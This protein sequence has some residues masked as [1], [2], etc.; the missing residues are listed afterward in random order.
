MK[1]IF[2]TASIVLSTFVYSQTGNV[3]INTA[4][5][6]ATLDVAGS[7]T[8]ATKLDGVIAPRITGEQLRLKT[9]TTDQ[10]GAIVYVTAAA[11]APL[12]NQVIKVS[13]SGYYYF[14]GTIWQT[15]AGSSGGSSVEPWNEATTTNP[16]TSN[17]QNIYQTGN[18]GIGN[19]DPTNALHVTAVANPARLEGLQ[20]GNSTESMV[21][22]DASG[23]LH[24]LPYPM[25]V[26]RL[27]VNG[28]TAGTSYTFN[29]L[30]AMRFD[31]YDSYG[32]LGVL[33]ASNND[34][35]FV[36]TIV[37]SVINEGVT[38]PSFATFSGE[39]TVPATRT[40][41]TV[42]L[43][44]GIYEVT[45]NVRGLVDDASN[46]NLNTKLRILTSINNSYFRKTYSATGGN[47]EAENTSSFIMYLN[48]DGSTTFDIDFLIEPI[49]GNGVLSPNTFTVQDIAS[50]GLNS[51]G[52]D[53]KVMRSEIIIKK[54]GTLSMGSSCS[55]KKVSK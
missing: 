5:P 19:N 54:I 48:G 34:Y 15:M 41:D 44:T 12:D 36:N 3:G 14:D 18:V 13:A 30:S 7:P 33:P 40:T 21:V 46:P 51:C 24:T 8:I 26:L 45:F 11:L 28:N 23:V 49:T 22:A 50:M 53:V 52:N 39:N 6:K 27:G 9:Y 2:L 4:D 42:T 47:A 55:A 37:G 38:L 35:N 16:A 10:T 31:K 25:Q 1:K 32:E 17:T 20:K 29:Q 43:P